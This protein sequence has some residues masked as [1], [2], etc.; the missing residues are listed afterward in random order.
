[1]SSTQDRLP[2]Q[3]A[4]CPGTGWQAEGLRWL[5]A[6]NGPVLGVPAQV[7]RRRCKRLELSVAKPCRIS[8][9][10]GIAPSSLLP[11]GIR[12]IR[13]LPGSSAGKGLAQTSGRLAQHFVGWGLVRWGTSSLAQALL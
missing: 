13:Q 9:G 1:M 8:W 4:A 12:T 11:A 10:T 7:G 2:A 3:Q 5:S 6:R